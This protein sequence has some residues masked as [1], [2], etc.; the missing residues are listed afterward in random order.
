MNQ[1]ELFH[2]EEVDVFAY[3]LAN[4]NYMK[5][6]FHGKLT[7]EAAEGAV[8][9]WGDY[10][11]DRPDEKV[12]HVWECSKMSSYDNQARI[13]WMDYMKKFKSNMSRIIII[14]DNM[15]IRGAAR[16]MGK[17]TNHDI[18]AYKTEE[19]MEEKEVAFF[20]QP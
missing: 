19:E 9:T 3:K 10:H 20:F 2:S 8:K 18:T 17:V 13:L 11:L 15:I 5:F 16:L 6:V 4:T 12:L 14:S 7:T 1:S